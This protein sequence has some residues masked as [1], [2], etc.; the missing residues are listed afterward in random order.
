M[1]A[2]EELVRLAGVNVNEA[3]RNNLIFLMRGVIEKKITALHAEVVPEPENP[4]DAGALK[5]MLNGLHVGYVPRDRQH[6]FTEPRPVRLCEW[7]MGEGDKVFCFLAI[8]GGES[9]EG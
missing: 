8:C 4:H 7:G 2:G 3:S 6:L 5:V 1:N 9:D